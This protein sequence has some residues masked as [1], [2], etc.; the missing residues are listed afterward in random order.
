VSQQSSDNKPL[1]L[2]VLPTFGVGGIQVRLAATID[3]LGDR[4]R[5]LILALDENHRCQTRIRDKTLFQLIHDHENTRNVP[6]HVARAM[7]YLKVHTPGL[8]ITYNWGTIDWA[9]ANALVR[10]CPHVHFEDGFGIEEA[11]KQLAR[12]VL[13]R[14]VVLRKADRVVVPSKTLSTIATG[15]WNLRPGRVT[16]IPNGVNVADYLATGVTC[17]TGQID[18]PDPLIVGTVTPL[19]PEKNIELLLKAFA[20][21]NPAQDLRLHIVG[22]GT[23]RQRLE[24]CAKSLN[25]YDR[26]IFHGLVD[27]IREVLA[28]FDVFALTSRTEQMPVGVLQAMAAAKPVAAFDIGDIKE[29][30]GPE[31]RE[32]VVSG[33]DERSLVAALSVL[34]QNAEARRRIGSANRAWVHDNYP[35]HRMIEAYRQLFDRL[36]GRPRE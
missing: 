30:V 24:A 2:H 21:L 16:Y 7:R 36:L 26:T 5:H 9:M 12:R 29:M 19:R 32:Y 14:A 6:R 27:D 28:G 17:G 22:D 20:E 23:E 18:R 11:D 15:V 4:Y 31:N 10:R 33:N 34:L 35:E 25:V 3:K 1:I 8:L 13:T